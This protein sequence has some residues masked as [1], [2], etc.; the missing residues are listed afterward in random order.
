MPEVNAKLAANLHQAK[1]ATKEA[2]WWFAFVAKGIS[3]GALLV[4]R[5]KIP[6]KEI[7]E[8]KVACGGKEIYR[9]RCFGVG[10]DLICEIAKSPP[11]TLEKQVK[12]II[13]R[14]AG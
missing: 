4:S 11:V 1:I 14:D 2:P 8:A 10:G 13:H 12:G 6:T 3:E 5:M 9:G 7:N